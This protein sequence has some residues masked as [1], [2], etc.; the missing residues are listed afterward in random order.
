MCS[1]DKNNTPLTD[2]TV[3]LK[4]NE[5]NKGTPNDNT[6]QHRK[7][8]P[9]QLKKFAKSSSKDRVDGLSCVR[10]GF[11]KKVLS[12]NSTNIITAL[13]QKSSSIKYKYIKTMG[14]IFAKIV[15]LIIRICQLPIH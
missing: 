15:T 4:N 1:E 10:E 5:N 9:K 14:S 7:P 3:L 8:S 2:L 11:L 6:S 12:N 13:W